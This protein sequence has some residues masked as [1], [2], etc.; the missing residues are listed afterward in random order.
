MIT[1]LVLI[2]LVFA[3]SEALAQIVFVM[4]AEAAFGFLGN[5]N[6]TTESGQAILVIRI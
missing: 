4:H 1:R 3:Q 6:S 5:R 2:R